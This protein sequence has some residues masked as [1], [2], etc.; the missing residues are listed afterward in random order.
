MANKGEAT[1][2]WLKMRDETVEQGHIDMSEVYR[3]GHEA[4]ETIR[5]KGEALG[6]RAKKAAFFMSTRSTNADDPSR[7]T[8]GSR[9]SVSLAWGRRLS[10]SHA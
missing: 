7:T 10:P 4:K 9:P 5:C 2:K 1:Y 3:L 8:L 6:F